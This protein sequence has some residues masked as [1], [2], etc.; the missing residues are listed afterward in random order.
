MYWKSFD[1]NFVVDEY[2]GFVFS[3]VRL[4]NLIRCIIFV[5]FFLLDKDL[6]LFI[7]LLFRISPIAING[8]C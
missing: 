8:Q 4:D 5:L 6:V 7:Y 3:L 2:F 1:L